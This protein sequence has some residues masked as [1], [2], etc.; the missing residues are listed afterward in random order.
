[1]WFCHPDCKA[2][3][4]GA[5]SDPVTG[6]PASIIHHKLD[7]CRSNYVRWNKDVF[8]HVQKQ[9]RYTI[10][11]IISLERLP[12]SD[13]IC[14]QLKVLKSSLD[15][16]FAKEEDLWRQKSRVDWLHDGTDGFPPAFFQR[17]WDIIRDDLY[18]LVCNFFET[19]TL[20]CALNETLICLVPM[21]LKLE[22]VD[23]FRLIELCTIV[24]K[25]RKKSKKKYLAVKLEMKKAYDRLEWEFIERLLLCMGFCSQFVHM[26]MGCLR[27]V[28]NHILI[29][30]A[31]RGSFSPSRGIRQGNPLSLALFILCSHALSCLLL[32][33]E[34]ESLIH[35]IKVRNRAPPITHLLF[36]DDSLIFSEVKVDEIYHLKDILSTYC[37]ASG[38]SINLSKSC[39]T[40]TPNTH[41]K[42]NRWFSCIMKIPYGS[43]PKKYLGLLIDFSI[44]KASLFKDITSKIDGRIQGWK[45]KLLSHAGKEVLLKFVFFSMGNYAGMHFKL[46]ASHHLYVKKSAAN[47]FWGD[48]EGRPKVHWVPWDRMCLSKEKG[49]LGFRDPTLHN[50]ALLSRTAH[51]IWSDPGCL[52]SRFMKAIYFPNIDFLKSK[53]GN[54]PSWGWRSILLGKDVL[55]DGLGWSNGRGLSI[56]P[57]HDKQI[58]IDGGM[59]TGLSKFVNPDLSCLADFIDQE[60]M[61]WKRDLLNFYFSQDDVDRILRINLRMYPNE[62]RQIWVASRNGVYSVK[63]A[64]HMLSTMKD[65]T[66]RQRASTSTSLSTSRISNDVWQIVWK[67]KSLPKI[68]RFMWRSR[69]S[70]LAVGEALHHRKFAIDPSC[71]RCGHFESITHTLLNCD[72]A[73]AVW[74]GSSFGFSSSAL[75]VDHLSSF[76]RMWKSFFIIGEDYGQQMCTLASF[77]L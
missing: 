52:F 70:G 32:K 15:D 37:K 43:G 51:R 72:F 46:P 69:N 41:Q 65:D 25:K 36:A 22:S 49:G 18:H 77:Y 11:D 20:S 6:D 76:I 2:V 74:F 3:A 66:D 1:M 10:A 17:Y 68:Q 57:W 61:Q 59:K 8:G 31:S 7:V 29:N 64:Y 67:C 75:N 16:L 53:A 27:Y 47:F 44:S 19:G 48:K 42:L 54:D 28:S 39:L 56:D 30:G 12:F 62:D 63:S 26:I 21:V 71:C 35:G 5:C 34:S 23:Q 4:S 58:P 13:S 40:F 73:K 33:A 55:L 9:I 60:S 24:S 38:Q 50:Q 45:S 14:T